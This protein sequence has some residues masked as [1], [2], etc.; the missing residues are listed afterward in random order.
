MGRNNP[1]ELPF[2][3]AVKTGTSNEARDNWT[4][5]YTP[6][7]AVGVWTGNTD[8]S[9]T[10]N[11]SG[12]SAA[13]F[14]KDHRINLNRFYS[15]RRRF[16][17][18]SDGKVGGAFIE[19]VPSPAVQESGIRVRLGERLSIELARGFDPSTL[20]DAIDTLCGKGSCCR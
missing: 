17:A 18:E 9:E 13:A 8:N 1:L 16:K 7:L 10:Q 15:W 4:V 5:G 20:R 11:V 2:P 3:A 6:G 14:C 19:L 12:L